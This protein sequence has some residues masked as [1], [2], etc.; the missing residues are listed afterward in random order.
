MVKKF[1]GTRIEDNIYNKIIEISKRDNKSIQDT[2]SYLLLIG[3]RYADKNNLTT[4]MVL[5]LLFNIYTTRIIN[6]NIL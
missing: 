6:H 5:S 3:I 1:I 4:D 2:I